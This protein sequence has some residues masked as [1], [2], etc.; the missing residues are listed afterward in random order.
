L[1]DPGF[2][3]LRNQVCESI[4]VVLICGRS[5]D[6]RPK[7]TIDL[8]LV[9]V[10]PGCCRLFFEMFNDLS[11]EVDVDRTF[12]ERRPYT[13]SRAGSIHRARLLPFVLPNPVTLRQICS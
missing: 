3:F 12:F 11:V 1:A 8:R 4:D 5:F 2:Y 7:H 6:G 9:C 13:V 10:G